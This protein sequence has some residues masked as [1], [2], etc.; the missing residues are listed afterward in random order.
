ME[1]EEKDYDA[2]HLPALIKSRLRK[3]RAESRKQA[4]GAE[5]RVEMDLMKS[6]QSSKVRGRVVTFDDELLN[7][8]SPSDSKIKCSS[9][10]H[11]EHATPSTSS[12][13]SAKPDEE[14]SGDSALVSTG[15]DLAAGSP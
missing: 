4:E 5:T 11:Q 9:S 12:S 13:S 2:I 1:V 6:F 3:I 8:S 14:L 10:P 7:V 15:F